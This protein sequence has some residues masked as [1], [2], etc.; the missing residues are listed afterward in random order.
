MY[1]HVVIIILF[2]RTFIVFG[3]KKH[4]EIGQRKFELDIGNKLEIY[5]KD[6]FPEIHYGY[7]ITYIHTEIFGNKQ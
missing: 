4:F 3:L 7:I 1:I 6:F 2:Q 5:M